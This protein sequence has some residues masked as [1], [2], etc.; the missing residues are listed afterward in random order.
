MAAILAAIALT[1]SL[2]DGLRLGPWWM[3]PL[4][5]GVLLVAMV[6]G[7]PGRIDRRSRGLRTLSAGLVSV[8]VV[9]ALWSTVAR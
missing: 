6:I 1:M 5:E 9:G 2:P 7:D 4:I 3:L 8:L